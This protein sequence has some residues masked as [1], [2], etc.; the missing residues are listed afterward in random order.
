MYPYSQY[1]YIKPNFNKATNSKGL[2]NIMVI[3]VI[4]NIKGMVC[5]QLFCV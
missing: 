1:Q 5:R 3:F 2:W 4:C